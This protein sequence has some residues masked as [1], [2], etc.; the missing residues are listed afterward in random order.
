MTYPI[1]QWPEGGG[2]D[3]SWEVDEI[4][5]RLADL[6]L[7]N[8]FHPYGSQRLLCWLLNLGASLR[9]EGGYAPPPQGGDGGQSRI[10]HRCWA[11][12][13]MEWQRGSGEFQGSAGTL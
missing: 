4:T 13:E 11:D 9:L 6:V 12:T 3:L 2:G 1:G 10:G 8:F 7:G 5:P